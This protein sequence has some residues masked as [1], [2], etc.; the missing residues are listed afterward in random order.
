MSARH[1]LGAVILASPFIGLFIMML[2]LAGWGVLSLGITIA[3][4]AALIGGLALLLAP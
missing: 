2:R 3:F 1:I 4:L